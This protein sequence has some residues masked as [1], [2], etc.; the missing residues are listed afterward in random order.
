[1]QGCDSAPLFFPL[2]KS[3][4]KNSGTNQAIGIQA[5]GKFTG[6]SGYRPAFHPVQILYLQMRDGFFVEREFFVEAFDFHDL[7][8]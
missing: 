2:K 3:C 4:D 7:S 8:S 1:M 5:F 6:I